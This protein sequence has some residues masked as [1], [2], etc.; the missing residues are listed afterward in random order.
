MRRRAP[1][2]RQRRHDRH[3]LPRRHR[4]A[5]LPTR[6][7]PCAPAARH[8]Q[9]TLNGLGERTGNC[10][11]HHRHP[12]PAAQARLRLPARGANRA[13]HRSSATTSPRC[14][15]APLNPQAPYVGSSAFAHKAGLHV[16]AIAR[17]KRCVRARRRRSSWAMEPASSSVRDGRPG[18][19]P[20]EGRRDR[21]RRWTA[22][23]INQ[24]IDDLKR[25]EHEGY[26]F[27]AA[28]ASLRDA[29][30]P[31]CRVGAA[32]TS[33][34][35]RMRVITDELAERRRSSTEATVKVWIGEEPLR[36]HVA[37]GNG[38]VNAIDHRPA[39]VR[40]CRRRSRSSPTS[41]SPT[42]RSASSMA[43]RRRAP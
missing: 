42:T 37:E 22:R 24:V 11:P 27:E 43:A 30:A 12:E 9:G 3:P 1:P 34:S 18:H 8:V 14:S 25:L 17:A 32:T 28:D 2:R 19:D 29:H 35:S 15:T 38:P 13:P 23:S 5:L 33:G 26:H 40:C 4:A 21:P 10:Q 31:C 16:S 36:V 39:G 41:T 20:D 6:W 7:Q